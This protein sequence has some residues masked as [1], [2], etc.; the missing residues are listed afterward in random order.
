MDEWLQRCYGG[1]VSA[2][3]PIGKPLHGKNLAKRPGF[4]AVLSGMAAGELLAPEARK[5]VAGGKLGETKRTH[6]I[7]GKG[8]CAPAGRMKWKQWHDFLRPAGA[9]DVLADGPVGAPLPAER[10]FPPATFFG[11]TGAGDWPPLFSIP[12]E[13]AKN[14]AR[15]SQ[16][17]HRFSPCR[18][19][20]PPQWFN[21]D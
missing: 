1:K 13:T 16:A 21:H 12:L 2:P 18:P 20:A 6:R 4:L 9:R 8:R 15:M 19:P 17:T 7:A 3:R 5:R 10:G 11:P 14:S